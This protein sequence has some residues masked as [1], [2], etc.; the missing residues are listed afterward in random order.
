MDFHLLS[1]EQLT[2]IHE[3]SVEI[4]RDPG[5]R[6]TTEEARTLLLDAGCTLLAVRVAGIQDTSAPV[7]SNI[8]RKPSGSSA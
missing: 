2:R 7:A 5:I 8:A 3:V 4:L 6:V 1:D